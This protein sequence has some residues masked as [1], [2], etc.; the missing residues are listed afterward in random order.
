MGQYQL[1][2]AVLI[3][4]LKRIYLFNDKIYSKK[5]MFNAIFNNIYKT[6]I[7]NYILHISEN[8]V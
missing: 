7:K 6:K 1:I 3:Y 8:S 2:N 5:L 4:N